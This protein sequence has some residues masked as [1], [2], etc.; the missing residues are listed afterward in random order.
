MENQK[1]LV[2]AFSDMAPHYERK[3]DLELRR[4]WG[5]SY[6]D[7]VDKILALTPVSPQD[8]VLDV[9]TGTSVLPRRMVQAGKRP[10][11]ISGLDITYKMLKNAQAALTA[12]PILTPVFLT[13]GSAL[14]MPYRNGAFDLITCGLATHHMDLDTL[15]SEISRVLAPGGRLAIADVGGSVLFK[16]P[17]INLVIRLLAFLY[18]LITEGPARARAES[19]ALPNV[20]TAEEWTSHLIQAGF[21]Q[22]Q[23][24]R[25]ETRRNWS[26]APLFLRA[27]KR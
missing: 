25:L 9:A 27:S 10:A 26:P 21:C 3:V 24:T 18:F 11:Q 16:I 8:R 17:G 2:E 22:V 6:V 14:C 5:W 7:L 13:C 15:L 12:E 19:G 1:I 20:F 4:F 23:V